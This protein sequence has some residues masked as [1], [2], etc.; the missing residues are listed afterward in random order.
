VVLPPHPGMELDVREHA[1]LLSSHQIGYSCVR[2]KGL[3]NMLFGGQGMQAEGVD[4]RGI[5][6]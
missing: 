6:R 4:T 3:T 5:G 2:V 1:F